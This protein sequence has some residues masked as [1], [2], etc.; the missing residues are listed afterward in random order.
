MGVA[1]E[2]SDMLGDWELGRAVDEE[3]NTFVDLA[4]RVEDV[5]T[6]VAGVESD[7]LEDW[8]VKSV[9]EVATEV[10]GKIT[11]LEGVS[12][13]P[14]LLWLPGSVKLE[15]KDGVTA[16]FVVGAVDWMVLVVSLVK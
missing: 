1:G 16:V 4:V 15:G 14:E 5:V 7:T 3:S 6:E 8:I 9:A 13:L 10:V 12:E 11:D 2:E